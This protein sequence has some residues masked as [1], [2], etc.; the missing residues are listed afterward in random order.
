MANAPVPFHHRFVLQTM[1]KMPL[2]L[3]HLVG[4]ALGCLIFLIRG[5]SRRQALAFAHQAGITNAWFKVWQSYGDFGRSVLEAPW[6][7]L[8]PP[9][10]TLQRTLIEIDPRLTRALISP[11]HSDKGAKFQVLPTRA[12]PAT[13]HSP[14]QPIVFAPRPK[15][16]PKGALLFLGFHLGCS[17]AA[18]INMTHYFGTQFLY[19]RQ[20]NAWLHSLRQLHHPSHRTIIH[21]MDTGGIR[22]LKKQLLKGQSAGIS[23]DQTPPEGSGIWVDF[24]GKPANTMIL[25]PKLSMAENV[26]TLHTLHIRHWGRFTM[27]FT[28]MNNLPDSAP[29]R[30]LAF[31]RIIEG[32]VRQWAGQYRW[33]Y[34]RYRVRSRPIDSAGTS[35]DAQIQTD[36]GI[37]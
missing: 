36:A 14:A 31:N 4:Y 12:T 3:L 33:A 18:M 25:A 19:Q 26:R 9:E 24:F 13:A 7:W 6:L 8:N 21:P 37:L 28:L 30:A 23:I 2:L 27:K 22:A 32:S 17:E 1:A 5:K 35:L 29:A 11:M 16:E 15:P 34:D 10:K 20:K